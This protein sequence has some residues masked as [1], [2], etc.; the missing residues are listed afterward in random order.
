MNGFGAGYAS[1]I[2][3]T[4]PMCQYGVFF[5]HSLVKLR[6]A[7]MQRHGTF[8]QKP[9]GTGIDS[10]PV[11]SKSCKDSTLRVSV[12]ACSNGAEVYSILWTIRSAR[13]DLR[14]IVHAVDL[15]TEVLE[16]G[17]NGLYSPNPSDL[18]DSPIF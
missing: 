12:L 15:S 8:F 18:V 4:R 7:R 3:T 17:K 16:I 6:S 10:C 11:K 9:S 1:S 2:T 13:P 14:V 5:L